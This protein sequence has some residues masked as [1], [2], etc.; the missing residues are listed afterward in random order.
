M[1]CPGTFD[2]IRSFPLLEDL[3]LKGDQFD[4][5][6]KQS[7][8][9]HIGSTPSVLTGTLEFDI[10][11][12]LGRMVG[13]LL[14]HLGPLRF[15]KLQLCI[16]RERDLSQVAELVV[17]CSETLEYLEIRATTQ[18]ALVLFPRWYWTV[19]KFQ[20]QMDLWV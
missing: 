12:G 7:G 13:Q 16:C 11:W 18:S 10:G 6:D 19:L 2:L 1:I 14:K 5:D 4:H 3:T 20:Q 9:P 17:A 15:R 8:R